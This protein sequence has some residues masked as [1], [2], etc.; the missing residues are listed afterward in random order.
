MFETMNTQELAQKLVRFHSTHTDDAEMQ[1]CLQ[2]CKD[3]FK[4][5]LA[6][7]QE[8]EHEGMPCVVVSNTPERSVDVLMLGH[9]D[10]VDGPQELF[11]G[12]IHDGKLYGRGTLDMKAFV[13]TS[14][15]VAR[16]VITDP[17]FKGTIALAIVT[18]E[19]LGGIHGAR[20][21][22]EELGYKADTVLVPD[23]GE[24]IHTIIAETKHIMGLSFEAVGKE[25]HGNRP[26]DGVNAIDL[27]MNTFKDLTQHFPSYGLTA[28]PASRW[29]NTIN[30]G[31]IEGGTATNEV[32]GH[33][34]MAVDIRFVDTTTREEVISWIEKSLRSGVTYAIMLE[35]YPTKLRKDDPVVARYA[36]LI[37]KN[38]GKP[39]SFIQTGGGTDARYFAYAGMRCI[40]HQGTGHFAQSDN[41][42]VELA[43]LETLISI[44]ETFIRGYSK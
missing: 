43:D 14:M 40:V 7:I 35:G 29:V 34:R 3:F 38:T 10:T 11:E 41:E 18:D 28:E 31:T 8:Y 32:P 44:Q 36:K 9:I 33:A 42:Y 19:E 13:A 2:F 24:D 23:D 27:L 22:V 15:I 6:I 26:W 30:L 39:A 5:T 1:A 17:A 21:L 25:A 37:E 20:Y 12:A 16:N 4:D